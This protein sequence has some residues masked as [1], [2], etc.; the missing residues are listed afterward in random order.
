[1]SRP[2]RPGGSP[3]EPLAGLSLDLDD[4]WTYLRTHGD[5]AWRDHPSYLGVVVPRILELLAER[6]LRITVFV[7]G[8]D[9]AEPRHRQLFTAIRD[10]GHEL[11]NHS[12]HHEQW[13]HLY[14][15]EELEEELERAERAIEGAT[16]VRPEGFRGPGFSLSRSTLEV[17]ERRGY[18]YDASTLPTYLGPLARAYFLRRAR[19]SAEEKRQRARLFGG[20]AEGLRPVKPYRFRLS[21]GTLLELPVTTLPLF[22]VPFH[23]SYLLYLGLYSHTAARTYFAAAL[24]LCRLTGTPPSLLLHPLDFL[25]AEDCDRLGFFPAMGLPREVKLR[26]TLEFLDTYRHRFEVLPLGELG[27]ELEA[28]RPLREHAP[29]FR[30]SAECFGEHRGDS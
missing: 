8:H 2:R 12:F 15:E 5:P 4:L 25:G 13:L 21:T 11:G 1:M 26:R 14:S 18:R 17:L 9:A 20:L 3:V 27:S 28:R 24:G 7:V 29:R 19:L 6:D 16:G 22:R 30:E 23:L 10:A